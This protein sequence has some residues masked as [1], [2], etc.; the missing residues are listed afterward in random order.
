MS[1]PHPDDPVGYCVEIAIEASSL[2]NMDLFSL[3][4]PFAI[5][6]APGIPSRANEG[7]GKSNQMILGR[8][9]TQ[10]DVLNPC[11]VKSFVL[12]PETP[13]GMQL[14]VAI[15]DR[16][17]KSSSLDKQDLIGLAICSVQDVISSGTEGVTLRLDPPS[18]KDKSVGNVT[19]IADLYDDAAPSHELKFLVERSSFKNMSALGQFL[20][21][22]YLVIYRRRPNNKWAPIFRS[23]ATRREE[24][25]AYS[26]D[27][28][29][30][31]TIRTYNGRGRC[32]E[33]PLRIELRAHKANTEHRLIGA[34]QMSLA[35][36]R[37]QTAGKRLSLG[38]GG[39]AVG[40]I[41]FRSVVL[42]TTVSSFEFEINFAS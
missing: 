39:E 23:K 29:T 31:A 14:N 32:E 19:L 30:S 35:S 3:S 26:H 18:G 34:T 4:D 25:P 2:A 5:L 41:I 21:K 33:T 28:V 16:D 7:R 36:L 15:Y 27:V 10:W 37:R 42:D 12:Q 40:E 13:N 9:E 1:S 38:L 17:S 24:D 20:T 22:P 6:S 8:T 11:F